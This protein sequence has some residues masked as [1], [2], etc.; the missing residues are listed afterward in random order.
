M[1]FERRVNVA[2][3]SDSEPKPIDRYTTHGTQGSTFLHSFA[4][5]NTQNILE[6]E[7]MFLNIELY[8][9]NIIRHPVSER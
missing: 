6:K 9:I 7:N 4:L 2:W 5:Q 1:W 8:K 3:I